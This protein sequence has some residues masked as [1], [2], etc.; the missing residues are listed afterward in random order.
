MIHDQGKNLLPSPRK[1][2]SEPNV[3]LPSEMREKSIST[4]PSGG[5]R[6]GLTRGPGLTPLS[7]GENTSKFFTAKFLRQNFSGPSCFESTRG[8]K[9]FGAHLLKKSGSATVS[10][11]QISNERFCQH[12]KRY[13]PELVW[14]VESLF[15][16]LKD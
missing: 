5:S 6:E 2:L 12:S 8:R 13:A 9:N 11:E 16:W 3:V 4:S 1:V 15:M 14:W 10:P 7:H